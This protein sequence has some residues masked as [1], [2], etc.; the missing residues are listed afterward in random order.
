VPRIIVFLLPILASAQAHARALTPAWVELGDAGRVIVRIVVEE[1]GECPSIQI[2]RSTHPMSLRQPVPER[3]RPACEFEIPAGAK[4]ASVNGQA[5]KLPRPDPTRIVVL[6][7]TGCRIKGKE[8]QNCNDPAKWPLQRVA[9][10]AAADAPHL[11]IHVGDFLYREDKC[12]DNMKDACGTAPPGDRWE[13]WAADFFTPAAKLLAA[14]PWTFSRGNHEDCKRSWKGWFYYLDPRPWT[15]GACEAFPPPYLITLGHFELFMLD[16]SA[17]LE[18]P[19]KQQIQKYASQ[20]A[21]IHA[22]NAWLVDHHPFWGIRAGLNGAPPEPNTLALAEA[23]EQVSPQGI[24]LI[25]SG[26]T[27]LFELLS[28]DHNHPPQLIAGDGSTLLTTP[29]PRNLEH[30]AVPGATIVDSS[31]RHEFGYSLLTK[32]GDSWTLRLKDPL[33][34]TLLTCRIEGNKSHCEGGSVPPPKQ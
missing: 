19:D 16:S 25:V 24:K 31:S 1:A 2:D 10:R 26:H 18:K 30:T 12:P 11:I 28:F 9:N 4:S 27:H 34:A 20:L 23:W 15:G 14:A 13:T 3:L 22:T 5:L 8:V 33:N 32:S 17:A 29:I 6:G 21:S 7:D